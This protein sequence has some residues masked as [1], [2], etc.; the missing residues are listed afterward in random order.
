M[1]QR[2]AKQLN[3]RKAA[4]AVFEFS[5]EEDDEDE[6]TEDGWGSFLDSSDEDGEEDELGSFLDSSSDDDG[7]DDGTVRPSL[8]EDLL[9]VEREASL[10][11]D[12]LRV[13]HEVDKTCCPA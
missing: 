12:L 13:E 5:N 9:R 10:E 2:I 3:P 6:S 1:E 8:Q 4:E 7:A 11:D